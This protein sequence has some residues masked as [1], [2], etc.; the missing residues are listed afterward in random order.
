VVFFG[1]LGGVAAFGF[2]GL[3]IGPI[4]LVTTGS[5]LELLSRPAPPDAPP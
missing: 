3:V 2:I 4:V 1:L 5:L